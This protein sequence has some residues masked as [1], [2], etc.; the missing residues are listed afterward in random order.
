MYRRLD[1]NAG[2]FVVT[3]T[4]Y[5]NKHYLTSKINIDVGTDRYIYASY[6]LK[7]I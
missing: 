1:T 3:I 7:D 4:N 5:N 2:N 6:M